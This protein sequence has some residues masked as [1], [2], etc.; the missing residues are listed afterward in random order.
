MEKNIPSNLTRAS[1]VFSLPQRGNG[2]MMSFPSL[3]LLERVY[4][5]FI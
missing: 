4:V 1:Y 3:S 2:T 5:C